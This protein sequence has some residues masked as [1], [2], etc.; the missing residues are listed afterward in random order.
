MDL[1][2]VFRFFVSVFCRIAWNRNT[3]STESKTQT[4]TEPG[5]RNFEL[6]TKSKD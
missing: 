3:E 1:L 4:V 5:T 2:C 6:E